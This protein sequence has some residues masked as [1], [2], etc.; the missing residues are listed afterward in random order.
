MTPSGVSS[1]APAVRVIE[2]SLASTGID[3]RAARVIAAVSGGADSTFLVCSL[4]ALQRRFGFHIAIAHVNH[5]WRPI[6]AAEDA[7][8]VARL[9]RS[10]GL[11][12]HIQVMAGNLGGTARSGG[13]EAA[14]RRG[15]YQFLTDVAASTGSAAIMTGHTADDQV[16]TAL[17]ALLRGRGPGSVAGMT[18]VSSVPH[19]S[20]STSPA[21]HCDAVTE[22]EC[23]SSGPPSSAHVALVRPMLGLRATVVRKA[24]RDARIEWREDVTNLEL[25]HPRNCLRQRVIPEL[26]AISPGFRDSFLRS[27]AITREMAE[28]ASD[29]VE[30]ASRNWSPCDHGFQMAISTLTGYSPFVQTALIRTALVRLGADPERIESSHLRAATQMIGRGRGGAH[31]AIANGYQIAVSKGTAAITRAGQFPKPVDGSDRQEIVVNPPP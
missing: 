30:A 25:R 24:L 2:R 19:P 12:V 14:A 13:P 26:E 15:R 21:V 20:V 8:F 17:L 9:G 22:V 18:T 16:E 7:Q 1:R 31:L 4:V 3:Y 11:P 29:V 23:S 28:I 5:G 6:D 27:L 10:L